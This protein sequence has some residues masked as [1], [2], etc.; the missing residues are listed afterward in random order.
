LQKH[1]SSE[2][3]PASENF[4]L[5]GNRG[6][7]DEWMSGCYEERGQ[8]R[9]WGVHIRQQCTRARE[10]KGGG[11]CLNVNLIMRTKR[12]CEFSVNSVSSKQTV[13]DILREVR[14]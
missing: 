9:E 11:D 10:K 14:V 8:P 13:K 1:T 2:S 12:K 7:K 4:Q 5:T 6:E 3:N